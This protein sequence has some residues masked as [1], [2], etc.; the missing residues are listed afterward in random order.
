[1]VDDD[2]HLGWDE[3]VGERIQLAHMDCT[4]PEMLESRHVPALAKV[5]RG[6][7]A[8][9]DRVKNERNPALAV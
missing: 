4:H 2:P 7:L 8:V 6:W 9:N 1:V 3:L 5:L